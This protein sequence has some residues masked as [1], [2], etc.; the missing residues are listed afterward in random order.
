M[1]NGTGAPFT[2]PPPKPECAT[3][4]G[5]FEPRGKVQVYV[6]FSMRGKKS[7][8]LVESSIAE[9]LAKARVIAD[10][11]TREKNFIA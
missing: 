5:Q 7:R 9:P 6:P 11:K 8:V 4:W 10:A 2:A 1:L 3:V